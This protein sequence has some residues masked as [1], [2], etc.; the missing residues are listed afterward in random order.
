MVAVVLLPVVPP[1][2][3]ALIN[4]TRHW[5]F[6]SDSFLSYNMFSFPSPFGS[7]SFAC[8]A[9]VTLQLF[10]DLRIDIIRAVVVLAQLMA[11]IGISHL[12]LFMRPRLYRP[13]GLIVSTA[14]STTTSRVVIAPRRSVGLQQPSNSETASRFSALFDE[15]NKVGPIH[16]ILR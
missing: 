6:L 9:T 11:A 3:P 7:I 1:I 14:V 16:F 5:I 2:P 13:L 15:L 4:Y 12:G 8:G 10:D